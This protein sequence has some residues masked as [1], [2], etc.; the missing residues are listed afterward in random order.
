MTQ[1]KV[2]LSLPHGWDYDKVFGEMLIRSKPPEQRDAGLAP[3][4]AQHAATRVNLPA[5]ATPAPLHLLIGAIALLL[6]GT[7]VLWS[8]RRAV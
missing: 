2:A 3:T 8:R 6:A 1:R 5:G 4:G 7:L